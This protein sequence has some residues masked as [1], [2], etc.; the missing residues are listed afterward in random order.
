MSK[1]NPKE[2][3]GILLLDL[4][5]LI[6]ILVVFSLVLTKQYHYAD[7]GILLFLLVY[8]VSLYY[9]HKFTIKIKKGAASPTDITRINCGFLL[10]AI[11]IPTII[12]SYNIISA[13]VI[14][15]GALL[16]IL[17]KTERH[18][19]RSSVW[20]IDMLGL[21]GILLLFVSLWR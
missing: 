19:I 10:Y 20:A 3:L 21:V 6:L 8:L 2:R 12:F 18:N 17:G 5:S 9:D 4:F 11:G 15:I 1:D 7:Y 13:A 14:V 16:I